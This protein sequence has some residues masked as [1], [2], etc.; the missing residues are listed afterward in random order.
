MSFLIL[1]V[2]SK[3]TFFKVIKYCLSTK[4]IGF[5]NRLEG[6]WTNEINEKVGYI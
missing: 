6:D 1:I 3:Y 2:S 5:I 4:L